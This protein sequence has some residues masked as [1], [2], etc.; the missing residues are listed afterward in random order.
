MLLLQLCSMTWS[1]VKRSFF[2]V[3][4]PRAMLFT[5]TTSKKKKEGGRKNEKRKE[6]QLVI[7]NTLVVNV[8]LLNHMILSASM[9]NT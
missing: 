6:Q 8:Q 5:G 7:P 1:S 4:D 2:L 9:T 3:S